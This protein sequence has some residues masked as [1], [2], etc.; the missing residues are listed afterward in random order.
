VEI[1]VNRTSRSLM[2]TLAAAL[3]AF[4]AAAAEMPTDAQKEAIKSDCR[5]DFIKHCSG[6]TPGGL[7]ALECLEKNMASLSQ[8][9]QAAVKPVE[10]ETGTGGN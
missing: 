6:V 8:A 3:A 7:P 10:A 1:S 4:F 2:I 5:S 9:C